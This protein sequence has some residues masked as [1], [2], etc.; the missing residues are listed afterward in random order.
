MNTAEKSD[1]TC[2]NTKAIDIRRQNNESRM[3]HA[4]SG[5]GA[6]AAA[7]K[8]GAQVT[9]RPDRTDDSNHSHKSSWTLLLS[10]T[11]DTVLTAPCE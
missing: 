9:R 10:A 3:G 2:A 5:H 1:V 4:S 8:H 6:G 11:P 7:S